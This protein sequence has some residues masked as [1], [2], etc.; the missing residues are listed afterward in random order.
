M[1]YL[2]IV[3][4]KGSPAT[5]DERRARLLKSLLR[6]LD[7]RSLMDPRDVPEGLTVAQVWERVTTDALTREE[8]HDSGS[9]TTGT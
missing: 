8:K 3:E 2:F 1:R 7:F 4:D 5:A 9:T 6:W